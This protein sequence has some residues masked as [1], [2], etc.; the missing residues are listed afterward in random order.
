M[1]LTENLLSWYKN[2]KRDLPWRETKDPYKIWVS[3]VMLQQTRVEAVKEKYCQF[4]ETYPT[5][6]SLAKG[7]EEEVLQLWQGLG[8]YSRARRLLEAA[9][10]IG[11]G[12]FPNYKGFLSLP[13]VGEYTANAV[14]SIAFDDQRAAVDGNLLRIGARLLALEGD[15]KKAAIKREISI[16]LEKNLPRKNRG[17]FNQ[18]L[19]DLG[20]SICIPKKPRCED[21]PLHAF[22]LA[23]REGSA[24][25]IPLRGAPSSPKKIPVDIYWIQS[26]RDEILL[27][28]RAHSGFLQGLWELPWEERKA[29]H[30]Q[31]REREEKYYALQEEGPTFSMEYVF[32]HKHWLMKIKKRRA[33][34]RFEP[35]FLRDDEE[36]RW[37]PLGKLKAM[38]MATVFRKVI[39]RFQEEGPL[40]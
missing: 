3:E 11:Q 24:Y 31:I 35:S 12:P 25:R 15:I 4:I 29:S 26:N 32:S 6:S 20:S 27:R 33:Q 21:C 30:S 9:K 23:F 19:M 14:F 13:G 22:C 28:R 36:Y 40:L 16:Y 18:A 39:E 1:P 5:L 2:H 37:A 7:R 34:K 17:D 10:R 38:E 8:Y